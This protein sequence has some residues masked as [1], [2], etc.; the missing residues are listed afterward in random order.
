MSFSFLNPW[1]LYGLI[2]LSLPVLA[3]LISKRRYD[4]VHWG[5]MQFLELGR[6]ARRRI[7]LEQLLLMLLRMGLVALIV[8]ALARP[9]VA[10]GF[11]SNLVSSESRD[12]VF[13]IDGSYS[14]GWKG[15]GRTPHDEARQWAHRFLEELNAGDTV[16][17]IDARDRARV[18]IDPPTR[19]FNLVRET[20]DALP[21]PSG[22]SHLAEAC[23]RAVQILT[24]TTNAA[25]DC[26]VLT[27]GQARGWAADDEN[28]WAG[29]D[30]L[31]K[32]SGVEPRVWVIDLARQWPADADRSNFSVDRLSL[33][34]ELTVARFPVRIKTRVRYQGGTAAASRQ[35]SLEVDG[36]RLRDKSQTY[37]F[38]APG[39]RG[40]E[41]TVEFEYRFTTPGSHLVSV[42][43]G[44]DNLPGDNR[45]DAAVVVA[46]SIPVLLVDGDPHLDPIRSETVLAR[47]ALSPA[48]NP[49]PLVAATVVPWDRL[50][51]DRFGEYDVVLLANVRRLNERQAG[52]LEDYVAGGGG[53]FV[54][55]GDKV[56]AQTWNSLLYEDGAGLLPA[57]LEAI[58]SETARERGGA[59]VAN[60]SLDLPWM[61]MFRA[62]HDGD[63]TEA[64]FLSW[65]Q[66]DPRPPADDVRATGSDPFADERHSTLEDR[67]SAKGSD[68]FPASRSM[69]VVAARFDTGDEFLV[70]RRYGRGGVLLMSA[71]IDADWSTLPAKDDYVTLLHELILYLAAQKSSRNVEAGEPLVLSV[72]PEMRVEGYAFHGPGKTVLDAVRAGDELRAVARLD[73]TSLPGVYEFRRR[74]DV[75]G[76]N[77]P[78]P[79][80][81]KGGQG[82]VS[83]PG[84]RT[85]HFV[86]N[87]DRGESDLTPLDAEERERLSQDGR[88]TF[89]ANREKL[90]ELMFT[91][92]GR[93]PLARTLLYVFLAFLVFEVVM[94]RRLVRGGHEA[95]EEEE[96][97][98]APAPPPVPKAEAPA[99]V[100]RVVR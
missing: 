48:L 59:R 1:L 60:E 5:A 83:A 94:T 36:Q 73:D 54:A 30:D 63:L 79:P 90:K 14:M 7:R 64:R 9:W 20:L 78:Y 86:V 53:L 4:I 45:A 62:E 49:D 67:L 88:L 16:T 66:V 96:P 37:Q 71:P 28:L 91:D 98:A 38:P 92:T 40:S 17:I 65:W 44:D 29:F 89:A 27:D 18:L 84:E 57:K 52:A 34:R 72:P 51:A 85:E 55:L 11:L 33:S 42:V 3:H 61:Q 10:G 23:T 77:P 99:P 35:V 8:L 58:E 41:V 22:T 97:A 21:P 46:E 31:R 47:A 32:L 80:L 39:P 25:R 50:D 81:S 82:G 75:P 93:A 100:A 74:T 26:I 68:P 70:T 12:V 76:Q 6:N 13:V 19:D 69:P 43:V 15:G 24:R 56:D 87:F 95:I 2:G